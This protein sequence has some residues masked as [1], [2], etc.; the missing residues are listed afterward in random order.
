MKFI[1]SG[2]I[3]LGAA[4]DSGRPW[5]E[6]R[7]KEIW[8]T[9][10]RLI[11][12]VNEEDADLLILAGDLFH[13]Q[14]LMRELKE[15]NSMF[16]SLE[17]AKVVL[18]AG[19]HDCVR[20]DSYYRTFE[21]NENVFFIGSDDVS[22]ITLEEYNADIYGLSYYSNEITEAKYDNIIIDDKDKI[23]ILVAHGG[24]EKHIPVNRRRLALAG[25]DYIAFGHIHI[26]EYDEEHRL[27]YCGSLEPVD[28]NDAGKRG[29]ISGN[30]T[31]SG[32]DVTFVP[33][34][35]R[36]YIHREIIVTPEDTNI[37][38]SKKVKECI[39]E[40]GA[41]NMYRLIIS[42]FKDPDVE[43][44]FEEMESFGNVVRIVDNTDPDYDFEKLYA[45]N[46]DNM[47]GMFIKK[48]GPV[49]ELDEVNRKALYYGTKALLNAMGDNR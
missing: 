44:D 39:R 18:I 20:R 3:H 29:Y 48:F 7:D 17:R 38:L 37:M 22:K 31:K 1:H 24:D 15:V 36:E 41:D 32:L 2:D 26:P 28:I 42:G 19:N 16:A 21:W 6:G 46:R 43:Y 14:P 9:F 13:R 4:P 8:N 10:G 49:G 23:N 11:E 33:F 35:R 34:S 30:V 12:R 47:V 27:A 25:F 45:N 5:A 40:N